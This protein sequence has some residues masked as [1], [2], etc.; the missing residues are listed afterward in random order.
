MFAVRVGENRKFTVELEFPL[1][2]GKF[3]YQLHDASMKPLER[4][5]IPV[6]AGMVK[7][8]DFTVPAPGI[9]FISMQAPF[10]RL[11]FKGVTHYAF[12][13]G[14][15][16][17]YNTFEMAE[18]FFFMLEDGRSDFEFCGADGGPSEPAEV[19]IRDGS[20][21]LKFYRSGR[22]DGE[23]WKK[24]K[25]GASGVWTLEVIPEQDFGFKMRNGAS[26]WVSTEEAALLK[27][28]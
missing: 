7:K 28:K 25:P 10:F 1:R 13:C 2:N 22:F 12:N 16:R 17:Q 19:I 26:G 21:K 5:S 18:K 11:R 8:L 27:A 23:E 14:G 3:Q 4:Q 6:T 9:Y 15:G 24:I 20:G